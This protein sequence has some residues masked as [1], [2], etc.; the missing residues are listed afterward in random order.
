MKG[1]EKYIFSAKARRESVIRSDD[2][3]VLD[4]SGNLLVSF[5]FS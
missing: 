4:T 3:G 2:H 1:R 5:S